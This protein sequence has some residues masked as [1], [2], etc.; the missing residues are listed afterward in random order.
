MLNF[1]VFVESLDKALKKREKEFTKTEEISVFIATWNVN[2]FEPPLTFDLSK[3]F[4][5]MENNPSPDIV[6][7]CLQ[8]A[9]IFKSVMPSNNDKI[10]I[11]WS[12][13]LT[14]SLVSKILN[15]YL[16]Y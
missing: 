12:E 4:F 2:G 16:F 13:L 8:D 11:I 9:I 15:I 1:L 6:V 10:F 7:I 14:Q 5:V 3:Q